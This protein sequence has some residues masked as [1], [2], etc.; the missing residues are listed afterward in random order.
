MAKINILMMVITWVFGHVLVYQTHHY[1]TGI[2]VYNI[3]FM[4]VL[5]F[6][7]I[8]AHYRLFNH[9]TSKILSYL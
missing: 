5:F 4:V 7:A 3:S 2:Y 1:L 9:M 6:V 8:Y